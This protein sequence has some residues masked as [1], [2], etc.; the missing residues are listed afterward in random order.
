MGGIGPKLY[1]QEF[2][3]LGGSYPLGAHL[4]EVEHSSTLIEDGFGKTWKP[5]KFASMR[6]G[7]RCLQPL[8]YGS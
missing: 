4:W 6:L 1:S 2:V 7:G 8:I 3:C 5:G